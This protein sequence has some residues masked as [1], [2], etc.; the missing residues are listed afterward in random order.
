MAR[1]QVDMAPDGS[2]R[3]F[4][5]GQPAAPAGSAGV[6]EFVAQLNPARLEALAAERSG[7]DATMGEAFAAAL[8]DLAAEFDRG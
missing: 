2:C 8:A 6:A 1:V 3:V 5:D 7:P 4:V